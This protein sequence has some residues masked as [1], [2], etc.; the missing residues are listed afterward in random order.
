MAISYVPRTTRLD[1]DR[2]GVHL[3]ILAREKMPLEKLFAGEKLLHTL[4]VDVSPLAAKFVTAAPT[5][6]AR[7]HKAMEEIHL[8]AP[9]LLP[10]FTAVLGAEKRASG[11]WFSW[12]NAR[13]HGGSRPSW[14]PAALLFIILL[15]GCSTF[16]PP[17]QPPRETAQQLSTS[18]P[19]A[20]DFH[21]IGGGFELALRTNH[22]GDDADD[23][24]AEAISL[25]HSAQW[26]SGK[27]NLLATLAVRYA[28]IG[29]NE[30]RAISLLEEAGAYEFTDNTIHDDIERA[31]G[32]IYQGT[33]YHLIGQP[34][35]GDVHVAAGA[36]ICARYPTE[37]QEGFD[38]W[39]HPQV[40][41]VRKLLILHMVDVG[42]TDRAWNV[43]VELGE[44]S[45]RAVIDELIVFGPVS[46]AKQ[47]HEA[48]FGDEKTF[49]TM[50]VGPQ[51][52]PKRFVRTLPRRVLPESLQDLH[53]SPDSLIGISPPPMP[54]AKPVDIAAK[55]GTDQQR[56]P[57][58][59]EG[60][61]TNDHL[62]Q[63]DS[64]TPSV[65]LFFGVA[66]FI[67]LVSLVRQGI[68]G[69]M[70]DNWQAN[71]F[72]KSLHKW[73]IL[74]LLAVFLLLS[75][76]AVARGSTRPEGSTPPAVIAAADHVS[77]EAARLRSTVLVERI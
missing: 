22:W 66:I 56:P 44:P 9:S 24:M 20:E 51:R 6:M 13:T 29:R 1:G 54:V 61:I 73:H 38:Q 52:I 43:F 28:L 16:G 77:A 12:R 25:A 3:S 31:T 2:G 35:K 34:Q 60:R 39:L 50:H 41:R 72:L 8:S 55:A 69:L 46:V 63:P 64:D 76:T 47:W 48:L 71:P 40:D 21:R 19:S 53:K 45:Q 5:V 62:E 7:R 30:A 33:A 11:R 26:H 57:S 59:P 67:V 36:A 15:P 58:D 65:S 70:R 75:G 68:Q 4:P 74:S 23:I 32:H 14:V 49:D 17:F 27:I 18:A 10:H 42:L 37:W